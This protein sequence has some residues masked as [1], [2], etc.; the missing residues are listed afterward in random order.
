M[1]GNYLRWKLFAFFR[2]ELISLKKVFMSKIHE[3]CNAQSNGPMT[4]PLC[5]PSPLIYIF[6]NPTSGG[7]AASAITS[8][9]VH[10]ITFSDPGIQSH[11][12][13]YNIRDGDHG[14]KPGFVDLRAKVE[15]IDSE[16]NPVHVIIAGGDG[17]VM[18]AISEALAHNVDM[19]KVAFGVIP[20][21]TGNDFARSLGW[22]GS[23]PGSNVMK[24]GMKKFKGLLK[25]YLEAEVI[26]FDIWNVEIK[27][28][29]DGGHIKQVKNGLKVIMKESETDR[30]LLSKPMCNY[31]SLGIESR[32]G[33]GFDKKR[34]TSAFRNKMRYAIEGMK[35]VMTSTPRIKELVEA[36]VTDDNNGPRPVFKE[37]SND[38]PHLI[39]NPVS[40]IFLNINSFAGGCDLWRNASKAGVTQLPTADL[41]VPQAVGDGKLEVLTYQKL[42]SLSLEQSKNKVFGGNGM[43][44]GQIKGPLYLEFKKDLGDKRTYLQIDG[45]FF[46]LDKCESIQIKHSMVVKVL[47]KRASD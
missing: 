28:A 47:R 10:H 15:Q 40:L 26:D 46:T 17:T 18:W 1:K 14:N 9:G 43:R 8:V 13:I 11:V 32:V 20:Y 3:S 36:C 41:T 6:V 39:G 34:T 21:G 5:G 37:N 22:G 27:A 7:N 24:D 4:S 33:L 38:A 35:K 30:K 19:A 45:E 12:F 2:P 29:D 44:I 42:V 23:S 25:Q 31:F 16:V